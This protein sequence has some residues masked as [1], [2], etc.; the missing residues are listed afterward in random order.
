MRAIKMKSDFGTCL[1]CGCHGNP[2]DR[3]EAQP[4][5]DALIY[6]CLRCDHEWSVMMTTATTAS[7]AKKNER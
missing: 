6:K 2:V 7:T 4:D 3:T 1:S 5:G